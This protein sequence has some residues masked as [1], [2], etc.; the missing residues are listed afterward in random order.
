MSESAREDRD[1]KVISTRAAAPNSSNRDEQKTNLG[2]HAQGFH[3]YTPLLCI[4]SC[5]ARKRH[6]CLESAFDLTSTAG[7][8]PLNVAGKKLRSQA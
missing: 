1:L 5:V 2:I 6:T 7:Q 3:L 4:S 8:M